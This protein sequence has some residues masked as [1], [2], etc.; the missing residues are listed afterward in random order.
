MVHLPGTMKFSELVTFEDIQR[1]ADVSSTTTC[2]PM[3]IKEPGK[4]SFSPSCSVCMSITSINLSSWCQ[5]R[6]DICH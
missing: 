3:D 6:M 5:E 4:A 1:I 2:C